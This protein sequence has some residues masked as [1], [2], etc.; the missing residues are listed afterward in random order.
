VQKLLDVFKEYSF[1][2]QQDV[3]QTF[4][5]FLNGV[6]T[7][8]PLRSAKTNNKPVEQTHQ[9]TDRSSQASR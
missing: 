8:N 7:P 2:W 1:L 9:Q 6:L 3:N 5:N 4:E